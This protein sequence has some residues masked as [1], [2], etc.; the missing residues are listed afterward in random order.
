MIICSNKLLRA[1][2][3]KILKEKLPKEWD[4]YV[5]KSSKFSL[6]MSELNVDERD[7]LLENLNDEELNADI[8]LLRKYFTNQKSIFNE[9]DHKS[10]DLRKRYQRLQKLRKQSKTQTNSKKTFQRAQSMKDNIFS[11]QVPY[12]LSNLLISTL[13]RQIFLIKISRHQLIPTS[14]SWLLRTTSGTWNPSSLS[15][16]QPQILNW[17]VKLHSMR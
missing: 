2:I 5:K 15:T 17:T 7:V 13:Y 9:F 3:M 11:D 16:F 8:D 14:R 1:K 6:P 10:E 12:I 4:K